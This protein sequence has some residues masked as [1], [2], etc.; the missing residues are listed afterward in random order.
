MNTCGRIFI[1]RNG[2]HTFPT[3]LLHQLERDFKCEIVDPKDQVAITNDR[4]LYGHQIF[5]IK[6]SNITPDFENIILDLR[7]FQNHIPIIALFDKVDLDSLKNVMMYNLDDIL[8][9]PFHAEELKIRI[10]KMIQWIDLEKYHMTALSQYEPDLTASKEST[11]KTAE[12]LMSSQGQGLSDTCY[13]MVLENA[14]GVSIIGYDVT[15]EIFLWNKASEELFGYTRSEVI[16]KK[17][18]ETI[19]PRASKAEIVRKIR[20]WVKTGEALPAGEF[21]V[22]CK[23][24]IL[25]SI[26]S[27]HVK[28]DNINGKSEMY[29]IGFDITDR[30]RSIEREIQYAKDV[31]IL[32]FLSESAMDYVELP[33]NAD[34][35][36][37]IGEKL[38]QLIGE[39][40]YIIINTYDNFK[41]QLC[42]YT[43]IGNEFIRQRMVKVFGNNLT[44]T[45][46]PVSE[47]VKDSLLSGQIH[48]VSGG[49]GELMFCSY[50]GSITSLLA[51]EFT[52][53]TI[54]SIG[55]T[56]NGKLYGNAVIILANGEEIADPELIEAFINQASIAL[57]RRV[58]EDDLQY[59]IQLEKLIS[60][61]SSR[62]INSWTKDI[63][64]CIEESIQS[65]GEFTR[66]DRVE[67]LIFNSD[68][69]NI[70]D[71]FI[72]N[73]DEQADE[74][75][76]KDV[77]FRDLDYFYS[78]LTKGECI[79]CDKVD[80]LPKDAVMEREWL[81]IT[82]Y[83]SMLLVPMMYSNKLYG[84]LFLS[85]TR[86]HETRWSDLLVSLLKFSVNIIVTSYERKNIETKLI[87]TNERYSLATNSARVGVWDLNLLT[88][89]I[90]IDPILKK[91][92]GYNEETLEDDLY[93]YRELF[94]EEDFRKAEEV[95]NDHIKSNSNGFSFEIRIKDRNKDDKWMMIHGEVVRDSGKHARRIVGT[96]IDITMIKIVQEELKRSQTQ[97]R[98][99]M[100]HSQ[101]VMEDERK[102]IAREIHD[103]LGQALASLKMDLAWLRRKLTN[104]E[105]LIYKKLHDMSF[106]IDTTVQSV[107]KISANLRPD[108][109][110]NLGIAAAI[111]WQTEKFQEYSGIKCHLVIN[112]D[113]LTL[114]KTKSIAI[115]RIYQEALTNISRHAQASELEVLLEQTNGCVNL[116][117]R[118]DGIGI[119]M[120]QRSAPDSFGIIGMC[121]RVKSLGG[122]INIKGING[123]GTTINLKI[124]Y[125]DEVKKL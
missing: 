78:T 82:K 42:M 113:D 63:E 91:L 81:R 96:C 30:K 10:D 115:F 110:D 68:N 111:E 101:S 59:R 103:E 41:N 27:S 22:I 8:L 33:I 38:Y 29:F 112:P 48:L 97:L 121:E 17:L 85:T 13:R 39:D 90:Y 89:E 98:E 3:S 106:L 24:G 31:R 18:D 12:K 64:G 37:H 124:P 35:Y 1:V 43:A 100:A 15:R 73:L 40:S 46:F 60:E 70:H 32:T 119:D 11:T 34:L 79:I 95:V 45:R 51:N 65:I 54:Y 52:T 19:I 16:G 84:I 5:L 47:Y 122:D 83:E 44:E 116:I 66:V 20:T 50:N 53:G 23:S 94:D 25:K 71:S 21:E 92:L 56:K 36:N 125:K 77:N 49:L 9:P 72:W 108:I 80:H 123:K 28:I 104:E 69:F 99:L 6:S 87:K 55:F 7:K 75:S 102:Q 74:Y 86:G 26:H 57:Q 93:D 105:E 2:N 118:D 14:S 120:N 61:I 62:F 117:I 4:T 109:L 107:K 76:L 67:L 114:D 58:S 88:Y